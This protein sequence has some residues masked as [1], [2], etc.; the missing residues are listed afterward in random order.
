VGSALSFLDV[1]GLILIGAI[2]GG[3]SA[4]LLGVFVVGMRMPFLAVGAAHFALAGAVFGEVTGLPHQPCAF[5]GAVIGAG[6]LA[7]ALR[8]RTLDP[9]LAIGVLF[10]LS[11]GLAFLGIGL[12]EGPRSSLLGLLWGSLLFVDAEQLG[13]IVACAVG[14]VAFVAGFD[15]RLRAML[16]SR[17]LAAALFNEGLLFGLFLAL[18]SAVIT[19]NLETV[20]GLMLYSLISNPAVAALRVARSYRSALVLGSAFGSLSALGGFLIAYWFDLPA[21]ACIVLVSSALVGL[22]LWR[23]R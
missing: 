15:A 1:F 16:F 3:G 4:G 6:A 18:A 17:E 19:V 13:L 20:G 22:A 11:M 10:S 14:L 8:R 5:A 21:G 23:C 2:V 9:N 12:A 7:G